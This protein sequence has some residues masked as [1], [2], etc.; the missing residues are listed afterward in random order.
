[1]L[2]MFGLL[3]SSQTS[4]AVGDKF[5]EYTVLAV[6]KKTGSK[7]A[8]AVV[9]CS[10]GSEPR[11]TRVDGMKNG[12]VTSC[13]CVHR[14]RVTKHGL[15]RSPLYNVWRNM[16]RRCYDERTDRYSQYGGRGI[17]V[18]DAWHD[19]RNFV[20]DMG[21]TFAPGLEIDRIDNDLGYYPANCRWLSHVGQARNRRN[22]YRIT[23]N[24][25]TKTA[26]EWS[27]EN[28]VNY[29]TA[30]SRIK[31]GWDHQLAVTSRQD[32]RRTSR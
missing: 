27:R 19:I 24:G 25:E 12:T 20:E 1:M 10:C 11:V 26:L 21:P 14:S 3:A 4:A 23:I 32:A 28:G 22:V 31:S 16:M 15:W 5:G 17:T 18:C 13:G 9:Q 30:L 7:R 2:E 29:G 6:G 8:Y